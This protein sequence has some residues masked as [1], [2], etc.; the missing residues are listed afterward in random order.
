MS[1]AFTTWEAQNETLEEVERRIH[2]GVADDQLHKRAQGYVNEMFALFP[3]LT[4]P[5]DGVIVEVGPGVGY[6]MQAIVE[7]TAI[8]RVIGLDVAAGMSRHARARVARD[9]LSQS[10]YEFIAY[11]GVDFPFADHTVD[12]FYSVAAI[13]HVPKPLAYNILQEMMRCLKPTGALVV[14]L[15]SW[16]QLP[17]QHEPFAVEIRRQIKGEPGHWHHFY[18]RTEL[19]QIMEH[20]LHVP[21][22]HVRERGTSIWVACCND[23][24]SRQTELE[25]CEVELKRQIADQNNEITKLNGAIDRV[26]SSRSWRL[27]RPMRQVAAKVRAVGA[28]WNCQ[29]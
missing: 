14:H 15:L 11:N 12:F 28:T 13:Q 19:E 18:D 17:H 7:R 25:R 9:G 26:N 10:T 22:F 1:S 21:Y 3:W 29:E 16:D 2:D 8:R 20:G 27:T 4:V 5:T 24:R 6:I 23:L